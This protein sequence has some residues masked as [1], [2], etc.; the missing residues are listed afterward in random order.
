MESGFAVFAIVTIF[1]TT[2]SR[3]DERNGFGMNST[4][5]RL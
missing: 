3:V 5:G 1:L 2:L 4:F